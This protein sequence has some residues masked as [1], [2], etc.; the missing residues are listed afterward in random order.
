MTFHLRCSYTQFVSVSR[1]LLVADKNS[2]SVSSR[3]LCTATGLKLAMCNTFAGAE[4]IDRAW[5]A[6]LD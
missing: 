2:C 5:H 1:A 3:W 4:R 6:L